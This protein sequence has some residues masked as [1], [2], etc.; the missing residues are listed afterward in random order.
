[1]EFMS[2]LVVL[3]VVYTI[4]QCLHTRYRT[5][6][7]NIPGPF[8]ASFSN[9]WKVLS[10]Y[11]DEMP[12]KNIAVHR[13]YGPVVRIGPNHVSFST[14]QALQIIH[15]SRQAYPKSDFY[16]LTSPP[17]EG[18][19]LPNL[20]S[21]QDVNYHA[22]LKRLLGGLYTKAATLDLEPNIDRT[23]KLFLYKMQ[24]HLEKDEL[25]SV[26]MSLWV[27][28]FAFD[29]IAELNNSESFGFLESGTDVNG[30]IKRADIILMDTGLYAQSPVLQSIRRYRG[31]IWRPREN[32]ILRHRQNEPNS[33]P[34]M[35]NGLLRVQEAQPDKFS[36]REL[37]A[38]LYINIMA[39]N[40]VLAVTLRAILYYVARAPRVEH[41]LVAELSTKTAKYPLSEM[42]PYS[43]LADLP[44]LDAVIHESLRI[45]GNI[46][47]I[48][49][50]VVPAGGVTIDGYKIPP[51][52]VVGVNPWVIH[53]NADIFGEDVNVFRPERWIERT[54][55]CINEMKK[56]LFSF[57][58][59]P[60]MCI[61][62]NI[63]MMQIYKFT[64]EFYRRFKAELADPK[65]DWH[66]TGNWVTKQRE[67][68]M[69]IRP[70]TPVSKD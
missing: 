47:L 46:G 62:K 9:L 61:G 69:L 55:D 40:D 22:S 12:Q 15:A 26:D 34:D 13:K 63:A 37:T 56:N 11:R 64:A 5:G 42:I 14:P 25:A 35:L 45:H 29:C 6:L 70:A 10:V 1:M 49:E 4:I 16:L 66:V 3:C 2:K 50:R 54:Q 23:L 24:E 53:H 39:G 43:A 38:A 19:P 41:K 7:S 27:H 58:A 32:P 65:K 31:A 51:G 20:F 68:D 60:R 8:L 18:K 36:I 33:S 57:G 52:T 48:C 21:T 59:G 67:M 17:F 44:Y 30:M 28:L